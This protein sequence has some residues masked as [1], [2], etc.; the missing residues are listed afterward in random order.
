MRSF[1]TFLIYTANGK[2]ISEVR[3]PAATVGVLVQD[4]KGHWV[5]KVTKGGHKF[6]AF[7]LDNDS[8]FERMGIVVFLDAGSFIAEQF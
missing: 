3:H 7:Q 4:L 8:Y 5:N 2:V 1:K 6:Q